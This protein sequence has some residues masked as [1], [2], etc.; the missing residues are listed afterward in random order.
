MPEEKFSDTDEFAVAGPHL[1]S[2]KYEYLHTRTS[3]IHTYTPKKRMKTGPRTY[4]P[5]RLRKGEN[6]FTW[7]HEEN[8]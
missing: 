8:I 3:Y 7:T 6:T 5:S 2:N 1:L 4:R